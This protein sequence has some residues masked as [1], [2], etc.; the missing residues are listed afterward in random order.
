LQ[1][2]FNRFV[3]GWELSLEWF[4]NIT[5]D[6]AQACSKFFSKRVSICLY[7]LCEIAIIACDLAEVIGSA[8]ALNLLLHIP[9]VW[10]VLITSLDV[11]I[12]LLC[13]SRRDNRP[14]ELL[15]FLLVFSTA[16]CLFVIVG[17][18]QAIFTD[19]L[20]GFL[21]STG[22]VADSEALLISIGIIGATGTPISQSYAT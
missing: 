22:I 10:G 13:W 20:L 7:I 8:I 4:H 16:I 19:V 9:L 12:I 3:Y 14:F 5:Q 18:S 21:P 17:Q 2:Y 15:I 1:S 11:M 6:L